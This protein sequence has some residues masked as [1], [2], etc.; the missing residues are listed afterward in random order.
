MNKKIFIVAV[1]VVGIVF[2]LTLLFPVS[3]EKNGEHAILSPLD[4]TYLID[5]KPVTLVKGKAEVESAP[6]SASK[7]SVFNFGE[8]VYGDI[9]GDGDQDAVLLLVKETGGSGTFYYATLAINVNGSYRGTDSILLGDR[10]APQTYYFQ[11]NK[12]IV[13]YAV[14]PF[15]APFTTQPREG[16]SLFLQYDKD[17]FRLIQVAVDFEG[18]ADPDRMTLDMTTWRWIRTVYNDGTIITPQK[19]EA[20]SLTLR[21]DGTV[22]VKTDCNSMS[23]NYVVSGK[24]IEF[25][26]M[27][28]TLMYCEGSQEQVFSSML[29]NVQSFLF[30]SRG[31]LVLELKFDSGSIIFR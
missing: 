11:G 2:L 22:S 13:N 7:Q 9:D 31:E 8:P 3:L 12:A 26:D 17:T 16:K 19:P 21:K 14:R 15:D 29:G 28:T 25:K 27:A 20:F 18:E 24:R 5:E 4:A 23:G 1:L 6:G 30:T 10:I